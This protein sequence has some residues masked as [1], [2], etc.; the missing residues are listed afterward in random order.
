MRTVS[1]QGTQLTTGQRRRL[2]EQQQARAFVNPILQ[3]QVNDTLAAIDSR[4]QLGAKPERQWFLVHQER[5]TPC[6][7]EL[8]GF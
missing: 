1:F 8:F 3:Q 6:V 2:Q 7:A 5:G 4:K